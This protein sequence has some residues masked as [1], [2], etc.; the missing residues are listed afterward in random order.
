MVMVDICNTAHKF[1][2]LLIEKIR[3]VAIEQ[4]SHEDS[5]KIFEGGCWQHLIN[6]W[7][8]AVTKQVSKT[9]AEVPENDLAKMP[10]ILR[11]STEVDDLP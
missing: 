11:I 4:G 5:I 3:Q 9:L 6:V 10:C 8:G 7:F 1:Q 2:Q